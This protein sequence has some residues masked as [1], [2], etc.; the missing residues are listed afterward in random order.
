[1]ITLREVK[2]EC[3]GRNFKGRRGH[4][5]VREGFNPS[6]FMEEVSF[7]QPLKGK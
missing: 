5:W 4:I 7:E 2:K 1:M 6:S 3:Y